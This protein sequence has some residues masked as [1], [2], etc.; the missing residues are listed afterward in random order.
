[1]RIMCYYDE[2]LLG[3]LEVDRYRELCKVDEV[4]EKTLML[5]SIDNAGRPGFCRSTRYGTEA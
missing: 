3:G 1:M 4:C 2:V 5:S